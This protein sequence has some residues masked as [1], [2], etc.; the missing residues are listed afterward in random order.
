MIDVPAPTKGAVIS[1][2]RIRDHLRYSAIS[3]YRNCQIRYYFR[4]AVGL[5]ERTVSS[6][7]VFGSAIHQESNTSSTS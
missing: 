3:T 2:P 6:S 1:K 4:Y 7:L 5:P